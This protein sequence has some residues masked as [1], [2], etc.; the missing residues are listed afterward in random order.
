MR[1]L[2]VLVFIFVGNFDAIFDAADNDNKDAFGKNTAIDQEHTVDA[3][4]VKG[5]TSE[6]IGTIPMDEFLV[7]FYY[8]IQTYHCYF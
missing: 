4:K 2:S 6:T 8:S 3:V 1:W 5:D 7:F